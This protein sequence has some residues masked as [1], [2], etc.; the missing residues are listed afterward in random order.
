MLAEVIT[1]NSEFIY[2]GIMNVDLS[3]GHFDLG[4]GVRLEKTFAHLMSV[5][6]M[7]FSPAPEGKPHPAP[8]RLAKGGFGYDISVE[9]RVPTG[10]PLPGSLD[11]RDTIWL[12]AALLRLARFPYLMV[13]IVS[14]RALSSVIGLVGEPV[15]EPLETER[16]LLQPAEKSGAVIGRDASEWIREFWPVTAELLEKHKRFASALRAFDACTLSGRTSSSLLTVWGGLEQLF[17]PSTA[18]LRYRVSSNIAAY[19]HPPGLERLATYREILELYNERSTAAHTASEIDQGSLIKSYVVMRNVLIR[20]VED[21]H[22]PTQAELERAIFAPVMSG[23]EKSMRILKCY[24]DES[25]DGG[26]KTAYSVA[27]VVGTD[28]KWK[29][30]EEKWQE[31]LSKHN[32]MYFR[33]ADCVGVDGAFKHLRKDPNQADS[34]DRSRTLSIRNELMALCVTSRVTAFGITIDLAD[35]NSVVDTPAKKEAF[36][37]TPYYHAATWA[38]ARCAQH[39]R[40]HRPGDVLAFGFD[41]HEEYEL[42]LPRVFK[43]LK[44]RNLDIAPLLTSIAPFDDKTC[45]PVQ[46]ADLFAAIVRRFGPS[47]PPPSE[48]APL[49]DKGILG[50]VLVCGKTAL[51]DHLR[52]IGVIS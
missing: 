38:I 41:E 25:S 36:G 26:G 42:E 11:S 32:I 10:I 9:L 39:V 14:D 24:M 1:L 22:I 2:G 17:S 51:E 15:L 30:L 7:A 8:W 29:W 16:R 4:Y 40:E 13:P 20:M 19:L 23:S 48:F 31:V 33:N 12:I 34:E 6:L 28:E 50:E 49:Q 21:Q 3:E 5:H 46:V 45:I 52:T 47:G 18:E 43:E 44:E 37:G 35:F 27:V